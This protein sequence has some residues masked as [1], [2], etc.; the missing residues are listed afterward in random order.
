MKKK[1]DS[2]FSKKTLKNMDINPFSDLPDRDQAIEIHSSKKGLPDS[3]NY[4]NDL[5]AAKSQ[6][7]CGFCFV[8]SYLA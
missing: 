3:F 8:F 5:G 2:I 4:Y 7:N 6:K 1:K